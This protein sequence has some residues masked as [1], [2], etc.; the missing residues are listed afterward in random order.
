MTS[1]LD[2]NIYGL[3]VAD[4]K[5]GPDLIEKI[6]Q[7][8]NF[9][10]HNFK[11]I[12]NELRK[13]PS[14]VLPVYD[15]LV[16]NRV[17]QE[18]KQIKDLANLYFKEYKT[19]GGVQGQKKILNDFKIVACAT[20]LNSDLVISEDRRTMLH[21]TAIK[22]YRNININIGRT[23]TFFTYTDLKKKYGLA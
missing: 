8:P 9:V 2:S 23:P 17:I 3:L 12:R 10:I 5:D 16:A 13:A 14:K 6:K 11:L 18:T 21:P 4:I 22:S 1:L 15:N 19:N 20:L 7:D